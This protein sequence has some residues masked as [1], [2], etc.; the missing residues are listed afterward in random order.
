MCRY[1]SPVVDI[2]HIIFTSTDT[3]FRAREYHNLIRCYYDS[4]S[5]TIRQL[6]SDPERVFS[7]DDLQ[8]ELK[9]C[10]KVAALIAPYMLRVILAQP[11]DIRNYD[12][13]ND[14]DKEAKE[15]KNHYQL[16]DGA[17]IAFRE[18]FSAIVADL[19]SYGY[20]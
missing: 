5:S 14:A 9:R 4:L 13:M 16:D 3:Q 11:K 8:N 20:L 10:G 19:I 15:N 17:D 1:A 2:L 6:G 7:F 18:R 12:Q